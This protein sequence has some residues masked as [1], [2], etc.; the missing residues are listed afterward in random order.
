MALEF[1]KILIQIQQGALIAKPGKKPESYPVIFHFI[2]K[3]AAGCIQPD[4]ISHQ[5]NIVALAGFKIVGGFR[6]LDDLFNA[7]FKNL[8]HF[9]FHYV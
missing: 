3:G 5:M 8:G 6:Q 4:G 7:G 1:D 2:N 9:T